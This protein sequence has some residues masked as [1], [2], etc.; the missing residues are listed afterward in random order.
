MDIIKPIHG[1]IWE[2]I[3]TKTR[4]KILNRI[5]FNVHHEYYSGNILINTYTH[6]KTFQKHWVKVKEE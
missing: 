1:E 5:F 2:N 4:T 3:H 6:Y